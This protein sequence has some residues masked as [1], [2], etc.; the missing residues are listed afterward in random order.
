M[1]PADRYADWTGYGVVPRE[2]LREGGI[3]RLSRAD[4]AV[5]L[6]LCAHA[7]AD[8]REAWPGLDGIAHLTGLN[9]RNVARA[10]RRLEDRGLITRISTGG[11]HRISTR[12]ALPQTVAPAPLK[13]GD[14]LPET[15]APAPL[16]IDE[17]RPETV[18]P[19]PLISSANSGARAKQQG[20]RRPTTVAPA[21]LSESIEKSIEEKE[22]GCAMAGAALN[23][24]GEPE[25][26]KPK[27]ATPPPKPP[28]DP[29]IVEVRNALAA[30]LYPGA[31]PPSAWSRLQRAAGDLVPIMD[32]LEATAADVE[33]VCRRIM[34]RLHC[35]GP[36]GI[37]Q[38]FGREL[39]EL[40]RPTKPPGPMRRADREFPQPRI[41]RR[42]D[43]EAPQ[44][45]P[46]LAR[47]L[48]E[49]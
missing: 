49:G 11:G 7:S 38:Q 27:K 17:R 3:R 24:L 37:V 13:I 36:E 6:V 10:L 16:K 34:A 26:D 4:L 39:V 46:E 1:T 41:I 20:R 5:Y 40:R 12:Y 19:A 32:S 25:Q 35:I 22:H 48:R 21:P 9:R 14:H 18:A 33:P 47:A 8:K 28:A 15:G 31:V 42:A 30:V 45:L 23:L 2:V 43:R 44:P 29:R